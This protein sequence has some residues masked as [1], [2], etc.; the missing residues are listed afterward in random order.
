MQCK[1]IIAVFPLL[2][3]STI[4]SFAQTKKL[5]S[6]WTVYNNK[7]LSDTSRSQALRTIGWSLR[8]NNPD[9]SILLATQAIT[10]IKNTKEKL[11]A[12][13]SKS[14]EADALNVIAFAW[15]IKGNSEQAMNYGT[16]CINLFEET[17]N[18]RGLGSAY[19][20]MGSYY[21]HLSNY[22]QALEYYLKG[23][24]VFEAIDFK[25][26]IANCL[27]GVGQ[28][29]QNQKDLTKALAYYTKSLKISEE[30]GGKRQIASC[31][32]KIGQIYYE[33]GKFELAVE[34]Q[35][36]ALKFREEVNDR[37]GIAACY[38]NMGNILADQH[39]AEKA[40][41]N[42]LKALKIS[43]EIGDETARAACYLNIGELYDDLSDS[44][45]ALRYNDSALQICKAINEINIERTACENLSLI[46]A[47]TGN[48]KE[49][50]LNHARF[51]QLTDSIFNE[52][53]SRE[54]G[55][56]KTKFEVEKR[57]AE[58]K[59]KAEAHH[60]VIAEEKKKQT[61]I[62]S[63]VIIVLLL[64][65]VFSFFIY[66]R[67]KVAQKQ[68]KVIEEQKIMVDEA[69]GK[70]H[71]KNTEVMDSIMYARRIQNALI[72]S[73]KYIATRLR[74]LNSKIN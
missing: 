64:V 40:I 35:L 54:L 22:P 66:N 5:D 12:K 61:Y 70:L 51:K 71:E 46:Y 10:L 72:T 49:A 55:D 47:Q 13:Q 65:L 4:I 2:F 15:S 36:K 1:R 60:L 31:L 62:I 42:Y 18:K 7:T 73:E 32:G 41:S 34:T 25:N 48:Y 11:T 20:N 19:S 27:N 56:L 68:K 28:V 57:E 37:Q 53:N 3:I 63:A 50:Y 30:I 44:K 67:F 6:L 69:Y 23:L 9:T 74:R 24:A 58:L 8:T 21:I 39:R 17:D 16:Q 29:Y 26:G 45:N 38:I 33:Q 43:I 52:D 59:A 14:F